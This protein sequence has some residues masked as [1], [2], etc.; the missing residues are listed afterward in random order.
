MRVLV[1]NNKLN[2]LGG[3]E[4]YAYT[5]LKELHSRPD[6]D[7]V[8]FTT[9]VGLV[10]NKLVNEG[11]KITTKLP[12]D[13][14]DLI[15]CSHTSTAK[16][17]VKLSGFKIQTCHGIYPPLEQ[18]Y[19]GV[20]AYVS[21]SEEVQKHITNKGYR[22]KIIF[23]GVDCERF[24]SH[25]DINEKLTSVLSLSQ[26][27]ELNQVL[28]QVFSQSGIKFNSL[29]KF[30]NPLFEVEGMINQADLVISLGRGVYESMAC[31]RNVLILDRRPYVAGPPLGDGILTQDNFYD[32]MKNNCS[33]RY[34]K[35]AY[36]AQTLINEI[37]KY[38]KANGKELMA[39]ANKELNIK[40]QVDKYLSI[41]HENK[42][43]S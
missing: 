42:K 22:S 32:Y 34:S 18:P 38:D 40:T 8:G 37:Q 41:Y 17:I 7:V 4:T 21:I 30:T 24:T 5:L 39:I 43:L 11:V 33:G 23:N 10:A 14:F 20:D 13:D 27:R 12:E 16:S 35:K 15:L 28:Q 25:R 26:S 2:E 3:S 1:T 29:N 31:G 36:N 9:S 19:P 6:I